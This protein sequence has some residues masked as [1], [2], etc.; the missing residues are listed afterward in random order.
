MTRA[1]SR[2][3]RLTVSD[4]INPAEPVTMIVR[5]MSNSPEQVPQSVLR[6]AHEHRVQSPDPNYSPMIHVTSPA[7]GFTRAA[8]N[9]RSPS[10]TRSIS[11]ELFDAPTRNKMCR[12]AIDERKCERQSPGV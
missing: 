3:K 2:A 12:A 5:I 11:S 6:E 10:S 4:P 1:P 8:G 7:E 9:C